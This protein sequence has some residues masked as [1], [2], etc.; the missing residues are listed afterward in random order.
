MFGGATRNLIGRIRRLNEMALPAAD[1]EIRPLES[2]DA[3]AISELESRSAGAAKWG[4]AAYRDIGAGGI[5]GWA[6]ARENV[7]LGFI[8]VR[9]LTDEMEI[10]NLAVELDTRR[11]GIAARLLAHAIEEAKRADVKHIYLEVRETNAAA[12]ALYASKGFIEQGRR[13]K[14]YSQPVAD[15]LLLVLRLH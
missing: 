11:K 13:K 6:A 12:R 1:F 15:A 7:L 2:E 4:E 9:S 8:L 14:Y 3:S 5:I 10:M